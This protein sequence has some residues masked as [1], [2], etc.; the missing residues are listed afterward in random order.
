MSE[1]TVI[2]LD[3]AKNTFHAVCCDQYG[4][5]QK[6]KKLR[7]MQVM[8][9]F[10][11]S[12]PCLVGMEGC[13]SAHYW[14]RQIAALGHEVRIVPAQH[15]KPFLRGNKHDFNDALAI[16][17]AA[18]HPEIHAVT[19]KSQYQQDIQAIHRFT[20]G[21]VKERSALSSRMR[22]LLAEYGIT[23]PER[24][25]SVRAE[26][27]LILEDAEN[28]L[29]DLFRAALER[30][31][32]QLL[33]LDE[34]LAWHNRS[35]KALVV[36]STP[37]Q[38]LLTVPGFGEVVATAFYAAIGDGTAYRKGRDVAA[39]LGL[40]P[41]QYSTGGRERLLG[42]SKRGDSELRGLLIHG[43]RAVVAK[44]GNKTDALSL[45]IKRVI[46]R[47]GYNKAVVALA[48]KMA[49]MGWAI[50][51]NNTQYKVTAAAA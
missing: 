24:I 38:N 25:S 33:H 28:G 26:I 16:A 8:Q 39:A 41:A 14:A 34:E 49:R 44:V 15:V 50:L 5:I 17:Q 20:R 7:R 32:Q 40:V 43:A 9:F 11:Q 30:S 31:Y 4:K 42:I 10:T 19:I 51:R 36:A 3:L 27:P 47:R 45:W 29:G 48:N 46:E 1:I 13:G 12:T 18:Q 37:C 2:G 21:L 6:R 23:I 35:L 22:G